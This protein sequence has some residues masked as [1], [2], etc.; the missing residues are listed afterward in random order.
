MQSNSYFSHSAPLQS[1]RGVRCAQP[2]REVS[3]QEMAESLFR[4]VERVF[5]VDLKKLDRMLAEHRE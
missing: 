1:D 3:P 2:Q 4:D 5:G